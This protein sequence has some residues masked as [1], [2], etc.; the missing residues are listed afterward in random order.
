MK[1]LF[2]FLMNLI[3]E[4]LNQKMTIQVTI[5]KFKMILMIIQRKKVKA[6][7]LK[8]VQFKNSNQEHFS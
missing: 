5:L 8:N 6:W 2:R 1:I 4:H 3:V 7:I